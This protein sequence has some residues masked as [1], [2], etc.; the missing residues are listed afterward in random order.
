MKKLLSII[1]A[2]FMLVTVIPF[3]FAAD[4]TPDFSDA[5]KITV[6][7]SNR[8][9]VDGVEL[10]IDAYDQVTLADGKYKLMETINVN[11]IV[12]V[13]EGNAVLLDLNGYE[14]NLNTVR[15]DVYGEFSLY[16]TSAGKTGKFTSAGGSS[17]VVYA[18]GTFNLYS[19]IVENTKSNGYGI[20]ISGDVNLYGGKIKSNYYAISCNLLNDKTIKLAGTAIESGDGYGQ[21]YASLVSS[22]TDL[23]TIIDVSEYKGD[24]FTVDLEAGALGKEKIF[25]G[26]KAEDVEKFEVN[27][28]EKSYNHCFL[29]KTEY[30]EAEGAIYIYV[31]A[32]EFTQQPSPENNYTADFTNPN[33]SYQWCEAKKFDLGSYEVDAAG[34]ILT[35][36]VKSGDILTVSTD[37]EFE[38]IVLYAGG[39]IQFNADINTATVQFNAD[40]TLK[41]SIIKIITENP[42][43]L[44]FSLTSGTELEGETDKTLKNGEC[45][46]SY[47]CK[48]TYGNKG[49]NSD[50]VVVA[51]AP[52]AAVKEN[53]V[54]P[55]C[56]N[57]GSYDSVVN[58]DICGI[59]L[60]RDTVAVDALG[61]KD[62]LVKVDAKAKT[63]TEIGWNAYE[64]CTA[65][66]YTTYVEIPASHEIVN[67]DAKAKT[68]TEIGWNAYEYCTECDYTTYV[69]IP[70]SHE[71]VNVDAKAKTCTEIGWDAYEYCTECDYTT[72]VEIPA[73]HEIVNVDAKA[74]TCTEI[75]WD[76]Y[77]YCSECDY[78]T[79]VEIPASHEIVNVDA[80]AKTC[81][82]IGW[83]AYEYCTACDYTTYVEIPASH[84][85]VNVDAK[86][87][88]CTT[89]GWDAYEYCTACDY[90]TY[91]EIPASH[92]I[93]NVDAKAK[94]CTEIGWNAYEHCTECDYT[95]YVEIPANGHTPLEAV[96]ENEVAPKCGVAGSYDN[97]VYCDMCGEELDR[98]TVAVDALTHTDADGDYLCDNGCGYEYEPDGKCPECGYVHSNIFIEI[99]CIIIR[100]FKFLKIHHLIFSN[101]F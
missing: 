77:T 37:S 51:H 10:T 12:N 24:K 97:V 94:T 98:E 65:C 61:H 78:T 45:G 26:V 11:N 31:T 15:V 90:T 25:S 44:D 60:S 43:K 85:I 34:D 39:W 95:T 88:T 3:V 38:Y 62:T 36:D 6:N 72:Y 68:C 17:V 22:Q 50:S 80:Q 92:E 55:D 13:S 76:A 91:V 87:K 69:E 96:K 32:N 14:W 40:E 4:G 75:G 41:I 67:V 81:T 7:A 49:Y 9:C 30:V 20:N 93:V 29:E 46:K 48:A 54:A 18:T 74:K 86:A 56:A 47:Y 59:E 1:L 64:Y 63:C 5:K 70:A 33:M 73:S 42:V 82:E 58:C 100:I 71:I 89:I 2:I 83:N 99:F 8:I 16:D 53:E 21:L 66:D 35:Y 28:I 23:E 57:A 79:Y 19:G 52:L 27:F 84:E 101:I